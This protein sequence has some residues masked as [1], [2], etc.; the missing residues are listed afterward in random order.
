VFGHGTHTIQGAEIYKGKPILYA[1]GHSTFDQPGYEKSTDGLV[2]R[3]VIGGKNILRVSFVPVSR[4]GN[5]DVYLL[6][7]SEGEGARL[8]QWV[9]ER[10][11][12]P[13][14]MRID[15]HEVVLMEKPAATSNHR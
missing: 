1:I 7:P 3:V 10:S 11:A 4:D 5:N 13:P 15:G 8:V 6:D 9:R 14:P 2:A 12:E